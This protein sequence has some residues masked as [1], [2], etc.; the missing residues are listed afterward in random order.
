MDRMMQK[1]D[2][3]AYA[4]RRLDGGLAFIEARAQSAI[5]RTKKRAEA[6]GR[7]LPRQRSR[8]KRSSQ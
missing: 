6:L 1:R 4:A 2:V 3:D 5:A 7:Y 8:R